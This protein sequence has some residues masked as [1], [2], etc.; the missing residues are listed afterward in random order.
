[1]ASAS[2]NLYCDE[3]CHLEHD[4]QDAMVLGAVW[5]SATETRRIAEAVRELKQ[6]HGLP[7]HFEVKWTKVSPAGMPFYRALLDFFFEEPELHFRALVVPDKHQL[8]HDA[9]DH[10]HDTWYYKMYFD[11]L[12]VLFEPDGQYSIYIDIKDTRSADKL[13]KLHEVLCNNMYDFRRE[14][15]QT[16]QAVRSHEVEQVQLADLLIGAVS[17]ANRNLTA[18]AAKT[19]LVEQMRR[20]SGYCLTRTTLLREQKVNVFCWKAQ[21]VQE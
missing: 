20:R 11:M 12:K 2:F 9:F 18:S 16:V 7:R 6:R 14:I 17:Y 13:A 3:S 5:H 8:R 19:K 15:L 1:M 4:S 10:E 21:E